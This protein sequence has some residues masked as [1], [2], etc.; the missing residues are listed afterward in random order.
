MNA[1]RANSPFFRP[2]AFTV[3]RSGFWPRCAL[4]VTDSGEV[5][6]DEICRIIRESPF[7]VHDISFPAAGRLRTSSSASTLSFRGF[8]RF[9]V[10]H[11][12]S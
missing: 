11:P 4:E 5:R 6:F 10:S 7:G 9:G 8:A 1:W 12:M 3:L 2:I